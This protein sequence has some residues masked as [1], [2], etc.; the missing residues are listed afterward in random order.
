[1]EFKSFFKTVGGNEGN[2]CHYPTRLDT[3]G[4]GCQHDCKYCYAKSLLSFRNLW[5]AGSP[6]IAN[7]D[8]LKKT[9]HRKLK[10]GDVVRLGGMTDCFQPIERK[11]KVTYN[12][13]KELNDVGAH[14]LIVT[15]SSL[16]AEDEYIGIMDKKL[17]HIQ[18][19][20]TSTNDSF[21]RTY[22]RASTPSQRIKAIEKLQEFGFDVS[23]FIDIGVLD[24]DLINSIEC[25]KI[26]V[27]FLRVNSWIRRWFDIDYSDYTYRQSGYLHMPLEKKIEYLQLINGFE[28]KSVCD[29][30]DEHYRYW[31][32][33]YNYN[34]LDCCNLKIPANGVHG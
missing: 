24:M 30:V 21:S 28:Q 4:R 6:S 25:D 1:M 32:E 23:Q 14:Y 16:V 10:H 9:I 34:N 18:V 15:K 11:Y 2:K 22:E 19:S 3:Y 13:I 20:I 8:A 7:L 17:A 31:A 33:M 29:D 26:L 5:D 27:E 12:A